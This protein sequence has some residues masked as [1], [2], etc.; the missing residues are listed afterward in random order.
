MIR[1]SPLHVVHHGAIHKSAGGTQNV[2]VHDGI[3]LCSDS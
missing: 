1:P 2:E 3:Q